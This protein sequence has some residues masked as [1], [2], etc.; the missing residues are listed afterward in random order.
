[1]SSPSGVSTAENDL[2]MYYGYHRAPGY[3]I[4]TV[5]GNLGCLNKH[6]P[7]VDKHR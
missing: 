7:G 4:Y 1:M 3:N 5:S 6:V 2:S